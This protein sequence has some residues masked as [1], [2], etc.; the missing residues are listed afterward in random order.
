MALD[1]VRVDDRLIHGQVTVAWGSWLSPDRIVLVNDDVAATEWKREMYSAADSMGVPISVLGIG[2][3]VNASKEG[4]WDAARVLV[5]VESPA[6]LLRIVR[7]GVSIA[8]ANIGGMHH[9]P[10]KREVLPYVY[11]DDR[12]VAALRE[13][14]SLGVK[15]EARDVPQARP[16]DIGAI[17]REE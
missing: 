17:L 7:G 1:L 3:F 9:S 15:L 6:D 5:V 10:G 16:V 14:D 8:E 12:D 13:L 11:V 2:E 4:L